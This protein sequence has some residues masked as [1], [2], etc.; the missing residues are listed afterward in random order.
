MPIHVDQREHKLIPQVPSLCRISVC[1]RKNKFFKTINSENLMI[2]LFYDYHML[3]MI[4]SIIFSS[5]QSFY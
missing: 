4:L 5:E 1:P 2:F 3:K